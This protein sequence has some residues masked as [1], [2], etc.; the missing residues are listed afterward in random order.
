MAEEGPVVPQ[1]EPEAHGSGGLHVELGY[2]FDYKP[3]CQYP[4]EK[5]MTFRE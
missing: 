2:L 4:L 3:G 5:M 1:A